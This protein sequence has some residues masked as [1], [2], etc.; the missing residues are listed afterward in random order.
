MQIRFIFDLP[1]PLW[2]PSLG[3][4]GSCPT[5]LPPRSATV[6]DDILVSVHYAINKHFAQIFGTSRRP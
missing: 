2:C 5:R 3:A 6:Y 4:L 1:S